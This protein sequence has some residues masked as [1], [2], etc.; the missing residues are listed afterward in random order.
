MA[1][2]AS[3]H[4]IT[5]NNGGESLGGGIYISGAKGNGTASDPYIPAVIQN[6]T[7]QNNT[8]KCGGGISTSGPV[9]IS[10]TTITGNTATK[11][12]K[13]GGGGVNARIIP[14][15]SHGNGWV[16]ELSGKMNITGN[17]AEGVVNNLYFPEVTAGTMLPAVTGLTAGSTIGVTTEVKPLKD[18]GTIAPVYID[19]QGLFHQ[20]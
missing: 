10:D 13:W 15:S 11:L 4:T 20:R 16:F 12:E 3:T 19:Q 14:K 9:K 17:N 6:A 1:A 7:I 8:A 2:A 5:G 18:G